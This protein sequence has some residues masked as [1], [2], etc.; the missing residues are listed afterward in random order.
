M[1]SQINEGNKWNVWGLCHSWSSQ[2]VNIVV[3]KKDGERPFNISEK[4]EYLWYLF[5]SLRERCFYIF[6]SI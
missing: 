4:A 1:F 3:E 6:D 2:T 5:W